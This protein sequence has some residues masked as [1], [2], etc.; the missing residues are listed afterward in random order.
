[1]RGYEGHPFLY[2]VLLYVS[3]LFGNSLLSFFALHAVAAIATM[4]LLLYKFNLQWFIR[5]L[6]VANYYLLWEFGIINRSY[7]F[8]LL[9]LIS[10]IH[11]F[12]T[13]RY[14][15]ALTIL[16][17][18][19]QI[20]IQALPLFIALFS[21]CIWQLYKSKALPTLSMAL[22]ALL[23]TLSVLWCYYACG[24]H[25]ADAEK[26]TP[27]LLPNLSLIYRDVIHKTNIGI[28]SIFDFRSIHFWNQFPYWQWIPHLMMFAFFIITSVLLIPKNSKWFYILALL[29]SLYLLSVVSGWGYRH[30]CF[31]WFTFFIFY[32][33]SKRSYTLHLFT[34]MWLVVQ[35]FAGIIAFAKDAKLPF[36]N[37]KETATYLQTLNSTTP[38]AGCQAYTIDGIRY[39]LNRPMFYLG[40]NEENNFIRWTKNN[41][42]DPSNPTLFKHKVID[43]IN[44]YKKGYIVLGADASKPLLE[45]QLEDTTIFMAHK[46]YTSPTVS[47][48]PD[49]NF[50]IYSIVL[51]TK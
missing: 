27:N 31:V 37:S 22:S 39:Y 5:L 38:I 43:Y 33:I 44:R 51:K 40:N 1:M 36:S 23:F 4:Y 2:F 42:I 6:L 29:A 48:V 24:I 17:I 45:K 28:L 35:A 32:L 47:I 16:T 10:A 19:I 3:Q 20:H 7:I 49:E 41:F 14:T 25:Y 30:Y 12:K 15:L 9:A 21:Y 13:E 8:I 26:I 18:G 34:G 11:Y 50:A 46:I